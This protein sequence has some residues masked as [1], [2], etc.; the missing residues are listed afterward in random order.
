MLE[1]MGGGCA[2][3]AD[4]TLLSHNEA[5]G[6]LTVKKA[7]SDSDSQENRYQNLVGKLIARKKGNPY[8]LLLKQHN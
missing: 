7:Y 8:S 2:S 4:H 5:Q 1:P 6:T 3:K